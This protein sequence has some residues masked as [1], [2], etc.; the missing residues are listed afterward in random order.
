MTLTCDMT[1]WGPDCTATVDQYTVCFGDLEA[2]F[3][4]TTLPACDTLTVTALATTHYSP[5]QP[6]LPPS[7]LAYINHCPS[8]QGLS[9]MAQSF[10]DQYCALVGPCCAQTGL[11]S[12]CTLAVASAAKQ[13]TYDATAG[14]AC[15]AALT[16]QASDANFC[17][18]LAVITGS[19]STP[20][21]VIPACA[22]AFQPGG[23]GTAAGQ[24]CNT[25][26]DCAPGPNGGAIS[27]LRLPVLGNGGP[28]T[29]TQTCQL[30]TGKVGDACFGTYFEGGTEADPSSGGALCDQSQ[31]VM[32]DAQPSTAVGLPSGTGLCV[33]G[34]AP[35]ASCNSN[36][37]CDPAT[38]YCNFAAGDVCAMRLPLGATCTG[39]LFG[40]CAS[41]ASCNGTSKTCTALGGAGA[42]CSP[43]ASPS[44]CLSG[45]CNGG[46]CTSPLWPLCQ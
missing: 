33:A 42:A 24:A 36:Y 18:G 21:A 35:G 11:T 39:T 9:D 8:T 1:S 10:V 20:W 19:S 28:V 4:Q 25:D 16:A 22:P 5:P 38:A 41:G 23:G 30:L 6:A 29:Y 40:E 37:M 32:C 31:G 14:M 26:S 12:D 7:C 15:L 43:S 13:A 34:G 17:D 44:D 2:S 3:L 46:T 45:L 27:C